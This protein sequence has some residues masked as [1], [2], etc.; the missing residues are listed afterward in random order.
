MK[1]INAVLLLVLIFTVNSALSGFDTQTCL[2]HNPKQMGGEGKQAFSLDFCR[3][4]QYDGD[5]RCCFM[6]WKEGEKRR[7][8]CVPVSRL[9]L[10]DIDDKIS[11]LQNNSRITEIESLDCQ[12]SYLF[13]SVLLILSLL[14]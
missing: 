9:E 13:V 5:G 3:T 14:L 12:S 7:Y 8:S 2:G 6:K 11:K 4:T 10:A 1:T